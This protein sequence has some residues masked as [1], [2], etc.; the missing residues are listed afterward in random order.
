MKTKVEIE[1]YEIEI[2]FQDGVISVKAEKD[3]ETIE[4]FNIETQEGDQE[5]SEEIQGFD[6]FDEEE[7]FEGQDEEEDFEGQDEEE[8]FE[9][10]DEEED[11][12][13]TQDKEDMKA[14]ESFQSFINKKR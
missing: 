4:E 3:D 7:D 10:Q 9:G 6:D 13:E 2:Q 5:E 14:L 1:G 11:E 12:F 8:D